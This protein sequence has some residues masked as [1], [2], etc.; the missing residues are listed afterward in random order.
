MPTR[1]PEGQV[2][3]GLRDTIRSCFAHAIVHISFAL[4]GG[5]GVVAAAIIFH[6][7]WSHQ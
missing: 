3:P 1:Q 7:I 4:W 5:A 2:K 6:A